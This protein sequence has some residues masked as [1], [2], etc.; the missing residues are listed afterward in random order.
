MIPNNISFI[1]S[2][3]FNRR[4]KDFSRVSIGKITGLIAVEVKNDVI[5][6]IPIKT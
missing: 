6:T 4:S 5:V 1:E 2:G 3:A